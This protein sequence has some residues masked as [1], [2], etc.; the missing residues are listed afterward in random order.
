MIDSIIFDVGN[1]LA[2]F[3]WVSYLNRQPFDEKTKKILASAVFS[4]PDWV[5]L[6]RG[7]LSNE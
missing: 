7:I 1:V 5:E 4:H 6:D 3:D 2:G